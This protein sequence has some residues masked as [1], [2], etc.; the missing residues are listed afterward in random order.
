MDALWQRDGAVKAKAQY[1][2]HETSHGYKG[3]LYEAISTKRDKKAT[4]VAVN[5]RTT[6]KRC[7]IIHRNGLLSID[8]H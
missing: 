6:L 1:S 4:F 7:P 3:H 8:R 5:N 2:L